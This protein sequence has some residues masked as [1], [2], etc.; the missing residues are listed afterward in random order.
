MSPEAIIAEEK[1]H[2]AKFD[3]GKLQYSL[4]PTE[5]T[6]AL[7]TVLTHGAEKYSPNSWMNVP[8]ASRRYLDALMRHLEA[9]RSGDLIDQDSGLPHLD[10]LLT[11]AAF[12]VALQKES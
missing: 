9:Y 3:K 10:H 4:I 12:L 7:A 2:Q 6:K 1:Y 8:D 11:N 5:A